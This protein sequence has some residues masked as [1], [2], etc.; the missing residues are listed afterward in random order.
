MCMELKKL[1]IALFFLLTLSLFSGCLKE[2][3]LNL[4]LQSTEPQNI[5]DGLPL[6]SPANENVDP[7]LLHK[8]Y[9]DIYHNENLWSLRGLLV[10]RNGKLI[11]EAYLK[12]EQDITNKHIIWSCT[13]QVM[14]VVTGIAVDKGLINTINDPISDYFDT[15][16]QSHSDKSDI[17][18]RHL[19]TMQSGIDYDNEEQSDALL[20][21]IPDNSIDFVL[22][23]PMNAPPGEVFHYNDGNPHLLSALIQKMTGKPADEYADEFLFSKIEM[24][25]YNWLRYKDGVTLGG[26]GIETTPRELSK[27]ALCVADGGK[28]KGQQIISSDWIHEM[29]T[30][31]A[32]IENFEYSFGYFWWIDEARDVYFM[33]GVGGQFAFIVPAKHLVV[34]MTSFPNTK[35]QYEIQADEAL[36][37]VDKIIDATN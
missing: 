37:I 36:E 13:K 26:F 17:T 24:T 12:D 14:G 32:S 21:Q 11:S 28:W 29:T 18:I 4:S 2:D 1:R 9:D 33:W 35:G 3:T 34:V 20:K 30:L 31:Q 27:I 8:I 7:Q 10:F 5:G 15:E 23:R 6:S 16:L 19:L 22:N 25:N